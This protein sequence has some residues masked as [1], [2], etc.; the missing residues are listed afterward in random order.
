MYRADDTWKESVA[1]S[2]DWNIMTRSDFR[3]RQIQ[4]TIYKFDQAQV[5]PVFI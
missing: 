2:F 4:A 1:L 3:F 5:I